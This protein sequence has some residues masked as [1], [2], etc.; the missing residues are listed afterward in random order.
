MSYQVII[1]APAQAEIEE[2]LRWM[3]NESPE[4]A[5]LWYFGLTE[6]VDR[7]KHFP[8]RCPRAPEDVAVKE[9]IRHLLYGKYRILFTIRDE[10][11]HVL[12]VR[13]AARKPL[14]PGDEE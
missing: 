12:H 4:S 5:A 10:Y 7:L 1:E 8:R 3:A 14:S 2:A 11:V 9:E 6:A 13:H